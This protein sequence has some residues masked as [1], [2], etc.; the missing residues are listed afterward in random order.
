LADGA[1]KG[2]RVI[3]DEIG[4]HHQTVANIIHK[5]IFNASLEPKNFIY[6]SI[7]YFHL[8]TKIFHKYHFVSN[9]KLARLYKVV[10]KSMK[11][12]KKNFDS[13]SIL[14]D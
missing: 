7:I 2:L 10:Q 6:I 5:F 4:C 12:N 1:K 11:K 8:C 9:F 3:A 13:K 14:M